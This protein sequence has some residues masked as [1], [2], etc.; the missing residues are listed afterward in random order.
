MLYWLTTNL[1]TTGQG[2]ITRQPDAEAA[3]ARE[4]KLAH[5]ARRRSP[6]FRPGTAPL[7]LAG[8]AAPGR[9]PGTG[10]PDGSSGRGA[11]GA[12]AMTEITSRPT[13]ETSAKRSG[14]PRELDAASRGS[15]ATRS[16]P[17][18]ERGRTG[19][20][21]CG[22]HAR[23]LSP[24]STS[25][26]FRPRPTRPVSEESGQA[27]LVREL[28]ERAIEVTGVTAATVLIDDSGEEL[29]ATL[30]GPDLGVLIGLTRP[31]H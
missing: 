19:I 1:W 31:S 27:A 4:A 10:H 11:A 13:G 5:A 14:V 8:S 28:L 6:R 15:T 29:L 18:R 30:A 12:L 3:A 20:L 22:L 26:T 23:S 24:A 17:G 7:I 21:R 16:L 2:I 25:P 9:E